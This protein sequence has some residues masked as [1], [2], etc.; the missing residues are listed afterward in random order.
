MSVI[1]ISEIFGSTVQG[2]RALIGKPT[3]FVRTGG[4]DFRCSWCDTLYAVVPEHR[5]DWV[6][7][8][9]TDILARVEQLTDGNP[10]LVTLSGG[11]PAIQPLGGLITMGK[12]RGHRFA[13]ETQGSVS[14]IGSP[15]W[16]GCFCRLPPECPPTGQCSTPALPPPATDW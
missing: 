6:P 11:S 3:V 5:A 7:M 13:M 4:C 16:I 12:E 9:P 15:P 10:I 1:R 8:T 14:A 2:E